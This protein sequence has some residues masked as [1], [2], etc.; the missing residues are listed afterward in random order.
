MV[1][2]LIYPWTSGSQSLGSGRLQ[3]R[4]GKSS[5]WS[6]TGLDS[7]CRAATFSQR[8]N[9]ICFLLVKWGKLKF[10]PSHFLPGFSNLL[11]PGWY[12]I[13]F[14]YLLRD[15]S[16]GSE[17]PVAQPTYHAGSKFLPGRFST[18]LRE[19]CSDLSPGA[20]GPASSPWER[21]FCGQVLIHYLDHGPGSPLSAPLQR[22][23]S[24]RLRSPLMP[25]WLIAFLVSLIPIFPPSKMPEN[26]C[27]PKSKL[28][29]FSS[30]VTN[31]FSLFI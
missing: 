13:S 25:G 22:R 21:G 6:K 1:Q 31:I 27:Y 17:L 19:Q 8:S 14:F 5:V 16:G 12:W 30:T 11:T 23:P 7:N 15:C 10:L 18:L 28:C 24:S 3:S 2:C 26:F 20:N 4:A 29:C 9:Y